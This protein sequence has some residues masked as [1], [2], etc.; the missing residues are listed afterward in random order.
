MT[1]VKVYLDDCRETPEGWF[2]VVRSEEVLAML[3][4]NWVEE[5][6]LDH[7]LGDFAF[8][9]TS[10]NV[11]EHNGSWLCLRI[12][13]ALHDG[14]ITHLPKWTIHSANPIG[15]ARM[16]ELLIK[17]DEYLDNAKFSK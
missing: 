9:H 8:D 16:K 2:R 13:E 3:K 4:R 14:E 15:A 12:L 5:L 11:V 1:K 17:C 6:S 7:D 10:N